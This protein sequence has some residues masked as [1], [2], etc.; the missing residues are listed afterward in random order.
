MEDLWEG[1]ARV[2]SEPDGKGERSKKK[3]FGLLSFSYNKLMLPPWLSHDFLNIVGP[4]EPQ[5]KH[6]D[7]PPTHHI[8][9]QSQY[10]MINGVAVLNYKI[11][12]SNCRTT[13]VINAPTTENMNV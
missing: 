8:Y 7:S 2:G 10:S 3:K 11:R 13:E 12:H 6:S 4:N 5:N 9:P 1:N